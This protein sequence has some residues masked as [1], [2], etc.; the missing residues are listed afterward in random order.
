MLMLHDARLHGSFAAAMVGLF[1]ARLRLIN[2]QDEL[3]YI[4][5]TVL[6]HRWF[7]A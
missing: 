6:R 2:D 5:L 3:G 7:S 1:A 4:N